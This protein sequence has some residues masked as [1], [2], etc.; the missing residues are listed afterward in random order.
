LRIDHFALLRGVVMCWFS[1][2]VATAGNKDLSM[3][4]VEGKFNESPK[5]LGNSFYRGN[6]HHGQLAF[7]G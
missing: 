4:S 3:D 1:G 2:H 6:M 5:S 7:G